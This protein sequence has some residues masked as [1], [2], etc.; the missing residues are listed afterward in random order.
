M[1]SS[2]IYESSSRNRFRAN[3]DTPN[4]TAL[5]G[6][7]R[8]H[9]VGRHTTS[10]MPTF[11]CACG[12]TCGSAKAWTRHSQKFPIEGHRLLD[13]SLLESAIVDPHIA[14]RKMAALGKGAVDRAL[15]SWQASYER[16]R[17]VGEGS[18]EGKVCATL[19]HTSMP[20]INACRR[21]EIARVADLLATEGSVTEIDRADAAGMSALAWATKRGHCEIMR[22]LLDAR[23]CPSL[24]PSNSEYAS[25]EAHPPLYL[26]LTRGRGDAALLLLDAHADTSQTEPVRG[27][28]ALHAAVASADTPVDLLERLLARSPPPLPADLEGCSPLH[29]AAACGN[30][31]AV[32]AL[33]GF[34]AEDVPSSAEVVASAFQTTT[35]LT[36]STSAAA[37]SS[38]DDAS[39]GGA[40]DRGAGGGDRGAGGGDG[41]AGTL[42]DELRR[43][44]RKQV[45]PLGAACRRR[46]GEV[47]RLLVSLGA[48]LDARAVHFCLQKG[49]QLL[50]D[51]LLSLAVAPR[52]CGGSGE[53]AVVVSSERGT[54]GGEHD[55]TGARAC[56]G[57]DSTLADGIS[58]LMLTAEAGEEEHV[59]T[60]L[61]MRADANAA[62][63]DGHTALMRAA[64]MGHGK[65]VAALV[66]AG[67]SVNAV[68]HQ[69]EHALHHA[70]R[71]AQEWMFDLLELKYGADSSLV[72]YKGEA[73]KLCE[74]P[75]R[76]RMQ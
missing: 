54:E 73:P 47:A 27:Q 2:D 40:G 41:G 20:L 30:L 35:Q 1:Y 9:K 59:R 4:E 74:E 38:G 39:G 71:G 42:M 72:N 10:G 43:S 15:E 11:E 63:R 49:E 5:L 69:G 19:D 22:A 61:A 53:G 6:A 28:T 64:F 17:E 16:V 75:C 36:Q 56:A 13:P 7:R 44:S 3:S 23:A 21:G 45:T 24:L 46:H 66:A 25:D 33:C 37:G 65:V 60:L 68:D 14:S 32:R 29:S 62:D 57:V 52:G 12:Y 58:A 8:T 51:E 48:P 50:L 76:C 26:A 18:V 31:A 55:G 67:A 70:G 34:L